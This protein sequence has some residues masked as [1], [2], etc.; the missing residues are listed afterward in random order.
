MP[1]AILFDGTLCVG[2]RECESACAERWGLP[3][4]EAIASEER[5]SE[6]KLTAVV[7]AGDYYYRR[8]CMHCAQ[9]S[10]ASVCPV[11][12]LQKTS[13]GPVVYDE[14]RCIGCRYCLVACAYQVPVYEWSRRLPRVRKCD[15]CYERQKDGLASA[16][17]EICPAGATISG[18]RDDII[19]E[20][21]RRV[22]ENPGQYFEHIYGI[23]DL[24][25]AS[26]LF[27]SPQPV[28]RLGGNS[29]MPGEALPELT[30][31]VLSL[32]PNIVTVV[33]VSMGGI[34]WITHR[35]EEV[36]EAEA[37]EKEGRR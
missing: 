29:G 35:R 18:E 10:C 11:K 6:R 36:A 27:V 13:L 30:W 19:V 33:A 1:R 37:R 4:D 28:E 31:R 12:A 2:C 7:T 21:R 24:G 34:W 3:Y 23:A 15:M 26:V 32:I 5:L 14:T 17:S 16:C 8:M 20:A 22:A 25:G 9:P